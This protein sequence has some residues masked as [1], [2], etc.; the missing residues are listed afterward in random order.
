[1]RIRLYK[2]DDV[3]KA[4]IKLWFHVLKNWIKLNFKHYPCSSYTIDKKDHLSGEVVEVFCNCEEC[5]Y[6]K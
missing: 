1:M 4:Q 3:K 2:N 5:F 6:K